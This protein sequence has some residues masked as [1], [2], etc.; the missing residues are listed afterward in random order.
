MQVS[1]FLGRDRHGKRA[2]AESRRH[3]IIESLEPRTLLNAT[4]S[5]PITAVGIAPGAASQVID[6]S[7]HFSDPDVPGTLVDVTTPEGVIPI[8]LTDS[9]TPQTVANF[10][11]YINN[12][13]YDN[14]IFHRL[15]TGF[16]FKA[17]VIR[18]PAETSPSARQFP[19]NPVP[20]TL[21]ARWQ[22]HSAMVP[23]ARPA[24]GSSILPITT[25]PAPRPI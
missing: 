25:A 24:N 23:L 10:L 20:R 22:W 15:A 5:T 6:L 14:T 9:K 3:T 18:L 13:G 17:A 11:G 12:G 21:P 4:L 1:K 7:Q 19:A 16:A 2:V 8:A